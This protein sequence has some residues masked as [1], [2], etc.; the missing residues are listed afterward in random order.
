M[1]AQG[2]RWQPPLSGTLSLDRTNRFFLGGGKALLNAYYRRAE[3]IGIEVRYEAPVE[4]FDLDRG[5]DDLRGVR[6]GGRVPATLH[7]RALVAAAGGFEANLERL[8][9]DWGD[10]AANFII[11]GSRANDGHV[12]D[13][14]LA[15]GAVGRGNPTGFHAIAVEARAPRFEGGIVTRVDS[16]PFGIVVNRDGRRFHDEGEDLWPKRYAA[17]GQLIAR[18]PEQVA[19]S[20]YDAKVAGDFIPSAYPPHSAATL[21]ELATGLGLEPAALEGTVAEFNRHVHPGDYDR[22]RLDG[23]GTDGLVPAKSHWALPIDT[24]PFYGCRLRPGITFTYYGLAVDCAARVLR[25]DGS[26]LGGVFAAGEI[27]AGSILRE[28]YLA[29]F[30]MTIGTVFGRVA[31]TEAAS[32]VLSA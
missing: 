29:G 1:E 19:C 23:C 3:R 8:A 4:E 18:Q 26:A 32:F 28:G 15:A 13:R 5:E 16:I 9:R 30:G 25:P 14:L 21:G 2:V 10:A 11:R 27:M 17:W 6:V 12:L 22:S 7:A 20:I 31:G 24:P